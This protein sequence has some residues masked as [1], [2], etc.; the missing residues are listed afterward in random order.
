MP[1]TKKTAMLLLFII[2]LLTPTISYCNNDITNPP[3][4]IK[5]GTE[6]L[7][8]VMDKIKSGE[9]KKGDPI[10]F[11]VE[12]T[13]KD[14]N[15][16]TLI[17]DGA[18]AFG[19][20][21]ES[22]KAGAFGTA[23]KLAISMDKVISFNGK[24]IQL[25]G[26]RENAGSNCTTGVIAG[27]LFVSVLSGFFRGVNAVIP[28]GTILRTYVNKTTVLSGDIE[29]IKPKQENVFQGDTETDHRLNE[30]LLK[31]KQAE[32]TL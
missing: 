20:V 3:I 14:E 27:M 19:T 8:R 15:G 31:N 13:V 16:I 10:E 5:E 6:V 11:I 30:L 22:K 32:P 28:A 25:R 23:G 1:I 2:I 29:E 21:S 26:S 12:K 24:D 7:L 18:A 17:E 4:V 9:V